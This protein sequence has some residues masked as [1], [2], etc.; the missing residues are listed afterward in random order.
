MA[1]LLRTTITVPEELLKEA[2]LT[3]VKEEKTLSELVR[4]A[5][6]EKIAFK[7]P[8]Y[9]KKEILSLAGSIESSSPMFKDPRKYIEELRARSDD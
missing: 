7:T 2:K 9:S 3:A 4:E 1:N 6:E 8:L 5:L